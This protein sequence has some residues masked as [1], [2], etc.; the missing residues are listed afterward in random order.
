MIL[1]RLTLFLFVG[2][3][4]VSCLSIGSVSAIQAF[5]DGFEDS[6][7][8]GIG[9]FNVTKWDATEQGDGNDVQDTQL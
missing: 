7:T 2:M 1:K 8:T 5:Y 9:G 6:S 3:V 4:F